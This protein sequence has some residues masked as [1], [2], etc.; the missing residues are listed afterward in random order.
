[1][2]DDWKTNALLLWGNISIATLKKLRMIESG[3]THSVGLS[4]Q[5]NANGKPVNIQGDGIHIAGISP[6]AGYGGINANG[7]I[8]INGGDDITLDHVYGASSGHVVQFSPCA[9]GPAN[10]VAIN[11]ADLVT[12]G[13][14]RACVYSAGAPGVA[15]FRGGLWRSVNYY[16]LRWV[17]GASV[18][19]LTDIRAVE[20]AKDGA[21]MAR[22]DMG[23]KVRMVRPVYNQS[24]FAEGGIMEIIDGSVTV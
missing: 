12:T 23:S 7:A 2:A 17:A 4:I 1:M 20:T 14:N 11:N 13:A 16:P 19:D 18:L 22:I 5:D 6:G 10:R 3:A 21:S 8:E 15:S 24:Q 9:L